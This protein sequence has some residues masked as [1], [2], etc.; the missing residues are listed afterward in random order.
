MFHDFIDPY[1]I[2]SYFSLPFISFEIVTGL[3]RTF[4][5]SSPGFLD[6]SYVR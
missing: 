3:H 4:S 5:G 2:P 6:I 1:H